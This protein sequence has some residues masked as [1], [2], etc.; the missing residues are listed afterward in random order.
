MSPRREYE[1]S[2]ADL[3][4][5]LEAHKSPYLISRLVAYPPPVTAPS[6]RTVA[7]WSSLGRKMGFDSESALTVPGKGLRFFTAQPVHIGESQ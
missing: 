3:D 6:K 5:L 2:Q 7:A 1:M 4:V